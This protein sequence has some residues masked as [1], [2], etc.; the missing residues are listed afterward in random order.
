MADIFKINTSKSIYNSLGVVLMANT[1][2]D[3]FDQRGSIN[4]T[5]IENKYSGEFAYSTSS[6]PSKTVSIGVVAP[7]IPV[8][9]GNGQAYFVVPP[10]VNGKSINFAHAYVITTG[11]GNTTDIMLTRTRGGSTVN[12]LNNSL[13]I[14]SGENGT[15][16]AAN[17]YSI[18]TSNDDLLTYDLIAI[19]ITGTHT[20][21]AK[22]LIVTLQAE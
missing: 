2:V 22:G 12:I 13:R 11:L 9:T 14:D 17:A 21:P 18:N 1:G 8:Q 3:V 16:S 19:N 6:D 5:E 10:E 20:T 15:D 4:I 7:T